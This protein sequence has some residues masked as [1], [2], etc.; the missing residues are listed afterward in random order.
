MAG[1]EK[2]PKLTDSVLLGL[3]PL[4]PLGGLVSGEA[5]HAGDGGRL[6]DVA[7]TTTA[8]APAPAAARAVPALR[9]G[10]RARAPPVA[11]TI[12]GRV[13]GVRIYRI[14]AIF[15]ESSVTC[16]GSSGSRIDYRP[17]PGSRPRS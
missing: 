12:V 3:L 7:A 2:V 16:G 15:Y 1:F 11:P 9:V 10:G 13:V 5:S 6:C 4:P 14:T 17:G 8:P